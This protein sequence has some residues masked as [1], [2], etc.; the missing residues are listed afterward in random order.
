MPAHGYVEEYGFAAMLSAT[1]LA[2]VTG[3]AA[4]KM[5]TLRTFVVEIN[6]SIHNRHLRSDFLPSFIVI[7]QSRI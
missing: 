7:L 1:R 3:V 6:I 4:V 2:D 5:G